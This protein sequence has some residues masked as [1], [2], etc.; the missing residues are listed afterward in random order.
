MSYFD[1]TFDTSHRKGRFFDKIVVISFLKFYWSTS[2]ISD[3]WNILFHVKYI[4]DLLVEKNN[5]SH[6]KLT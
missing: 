6:D 4:G 2:R 1:K 3:Q 5:E